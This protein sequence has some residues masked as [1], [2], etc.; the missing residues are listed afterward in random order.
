MRACRE[1]LS[2]YCQSL[3]IELLDTRIERLQRTITRLTNLTQEIHTL[4]ILLRSGMHFS[5]APPGRSGNLP[6]KISAGP[7]RVQGTGIKV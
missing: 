4:R 1:A 3:R 6:L 5:F 7:G 2:S